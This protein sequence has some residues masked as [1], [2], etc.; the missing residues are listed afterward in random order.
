V[1][2]LSVIERC[3]EDDIRSHELLGEESD[4]KAKF[5]TGTR[6]YVTVR[7][8]RR[9]PVGLARYAYRGA[10]RPRLRRAYR[11]WRPAA[12]WVPVGCGIAEST[13]AS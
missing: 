2:R 7:A 4:W 5:A 9:N 13:P 3:F 1:M 10:I 12:V 8:Y 6:P 11:R